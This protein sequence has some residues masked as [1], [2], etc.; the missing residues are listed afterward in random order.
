MKKTL[1]VLLASIVSF[2][3][4]QCD[5]NTTTKTI[6]GDTTVIKLDFKAEKTNVHEIGLI[7][8]IKLLRLDCEEVIGEIRKVVRHNDR[9][10]LMDSQTSKVFIFDVEG[11]YINHIARRG[12]GPEEYL[13]LVDIFVDP[14]D[15]T[16]NLVS[17]LDKKVLKFDA[18]GS[19]LLKIERTPKSFHNLLITEDGYLGYMNN[20]REDS[21]QPYNVWTVTPKMKLGEG[22]FEI[23]PSWSSKGFGDGSV[24]SNYGDLVYY[25]TL[26]DFNIYAFRNGELSIPYRFDLGA[27]AWPEDK[28]D[29]SEYEKV[30]GSLEYPHILHFYYF[31]ET[32]N[33][34]ITNIV[35]EGQD[36][37]G[38]YDKRNG[39][40]YIAKLEGSFVESV[41]SFGRIISFDE[42]AIYTY[43]DASS[44]SF[45]RKGGYEGDLEERYPEQVKRLRERFSEID[46]ED[47]PFLVI[48]TIN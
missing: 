4:V 5:T 13:Q 1:H 46:E 31:Q 26:M 3:L 43:I 9:L 41:F 6:S 45:F 42:H 47:N 29:Y 38:V 10:Y 12:Q 17:R 48:Y 36:L 15:A 28:K 24:F 40:T 16:L 7:D 32:E 33:H 21:S 34:L 35:R 22:F 30:R 14:A 8:D 11:A 44:M 25:I 27:L 18:D 23:D 37:L 39:K 2:L 20:F 19:R